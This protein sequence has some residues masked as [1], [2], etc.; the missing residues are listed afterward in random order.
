MREANVCLGL[1]ASLGLHC[2][3]STQGMIRYAPGAVPGATS[4]QSF[5]DANADGFTDFIVWHS[6]LYHPQGSMRVYSGADSSM[7]LEI[8][9]PSANVVGDVDGD[10]QMDLGR[11]NWLANGGY[12]SIEVIS[13]AT[14]SMLY[15]VDG[16]VAPSD[17]NF[18][19]GIW[20]AGDANADGYDDVLVGSFIAGGTGYTRAIVLSGIDGSLLYYVNAPDGLVLHGEVGDVT[21]DGFDDL[22]VIALTGHEIRVYSGRT[23]T[24][25]FTILRTTFGFDQSDNYGLM[26]PA[27][28]GDVDGDGFGDILVGMPALDSGHGGLSVI[29]GA[30]GARIFGYRGLN[31]SGVSQGDLFARSAAGVGDVDGDGFADYAVGAPYEGVDDKGSIRVYSGIDGHRIHKFLGVLT[32]AHLGAQ[33]DGGVGCDVNGDG[34]DDVLAGN[35]AAGA[36]VFGLGAGGIPGRMQT[37]GEA[38][39]GSRGMPRIG[40]DGRPRIG[41]A[42]G[43]TLRGAA[44]N[45]SVVWLQI[46]TEDDVPLDAIGLAGCS[47]YQAPFVTFRSSTDADGMARFDLG[48]PN[49][50]GWIGLPLTM[51]WLIADFAL[52][53]PFPVATS[54][55]LWVSV[56]Y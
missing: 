36:F 50:L 3:A 25:A 4:V 1:V 54:D 2:P 7:L 5:G 9:G 46:G 17:W 14:G 35:S 40:F 15:Q 41:T 42:F 39:P 29:S 8:V 16:P 23:H 53:T 51:Q 22:A 43:V 21:G 32:D 27:R 24:I 13:G 10:G 49:E 20:A 47:L 6:T 28:A 52:G 45:S 19:N 48:L 38:C 12:G 37:R 33:I 31:M 11:S 34:F 55:A 30:T 26:H 44:E 18:G 56:G